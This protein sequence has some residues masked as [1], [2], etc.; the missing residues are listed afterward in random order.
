MDETVNEICRQI[1]GLVPYASFQN[2]TYTFLHR[3]LVGLLLIAPLCAAVGIPVVNFRLAFFAEAIGHSAFTG[4]AIGLA[5]ASMPGMIGIDPL[6]P[7]ILFG[8]AVS[9]A[10]TYY[11]R[12]TDLSSDTVIGVFSSGAVAFGLCIIMHLISVNKGID[13]DTFNN[14]LTGNILSITPR[15]IV[16]LL[17]FFA[18]SL[19]YQAVTYNR[20]LLVGLNENLAHSLGVRV[21]YYEYSFAI[22]LALVVMFSIK[23]VGVLMVTALLVVPAA[24]ARNLARTAGGMYWWAVSVSLFSTLVGLIISDHFDTATGAT[25]I[26]TACGCFAVSHLVARAGRRA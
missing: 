10:I 7:M 23:A 21:A 26:V 13:R 14:F 5:A 2:P 17:V 24:T 9:L 3:A 6:I 20:Q 11:R 8:V 22:L 1:A 18:F 12:A 25:A 15:D 19:V 4:I 16:V